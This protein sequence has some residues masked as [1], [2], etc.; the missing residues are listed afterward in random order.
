[1]DRGAGLS[2]AALCNLVGILREREEAMRRLTRLLAA[3]AVA[4]LAACDPSGQAYEDLRL[5]QLKSGQSTE[6]EV[7]KLFGKP[8]AV[9]D[10]GSGRGLVYP[11]GPEGVHTLLL[12]I[13]PDGRYQGREDLLTRA[14]FQ[15]VNTGMKQVDVLRVL[16]PPG[17]T[18]E[19]RMKQET[20]WEYRFKDGAE[21]RTF[22]V[23]FNSGGQVVSTAVEENPR[24][25]G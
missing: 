18:Q 7:L 6:A 8:Y 24:V 1:M 9:R 5:A 16:G 4:L 3:A 22:V 13:G 15:T 14:N 20:A 21:T 17:R 12:K 11:L 10:I 2:N 25:G 19:Y 23:M